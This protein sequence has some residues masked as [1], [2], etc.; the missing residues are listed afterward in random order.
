M[1]TL[2]STLK[3]SFPLALFLLGTVACKNEAA[4][5]QEE[6]GKEIVLN[7]EGAIDAEIAAITETVAKEG[8]LMSSLSYS[9]E[10][11]EVYQVHAH[12]S[13]GKILKLDEEFN[14]GP[15][16]NHGINSFF[17]KGDDVIATRE[18]YEDNTSTPEQSMFVER[19]TYY[20]P[21]G[22]VLKSKEK[23]VAYEEQIEASTF[24][25]VS[26][27]GL[28]IDK[29]KRALNQEQEFMT[30]FQ[31]IV[32]ESGLH[33]IVIGSD[34]PD[35]YTSAVRADQE[36]DF[37]RFLVNNQKACVGK[38]VAIT[39]E[40]VTEDNGFTYQAYRSGGFNEK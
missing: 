32:T 5:Q 21:K 17:L 12:L 11:G 22:K 35:S 23:R 3:F 38:K 10:N 1:S 7:N 37:V 16:K 8:Q 4:D 9:R 13:G 14:D 40:T 25:Q 18:Y 15:G 19:I 2:K 36:D 26:S 6:A 39:F 33:Y 34:G 29:A 27:K 31:G 30:S 28:K 24:K 20:D